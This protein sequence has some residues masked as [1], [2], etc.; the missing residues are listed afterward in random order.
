MRLF[1]PFFFF[2]FL[3]CA[4]MNKTFSY[5]ATSGLSGNTK[6]HPSD[7]NKAFFADINLL[8]VIEFSNELFS[9]IEK[10][11]LCLFQKNFFY[12]KA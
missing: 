5:S 9:Y 4:E 2:Y 12:V 7:F 10:I 6:Q 3:L 1:I 8:F 11:L